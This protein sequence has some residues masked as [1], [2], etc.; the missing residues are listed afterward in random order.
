MDS[1]ESSNANLGTLALQHAENR[2][3]EF[4]SSLGRSMRA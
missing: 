2:P 4:F 1:P 3:R